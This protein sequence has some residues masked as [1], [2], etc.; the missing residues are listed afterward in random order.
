[1][2]GWFMK[3]TCRSRPLSS[4]TATGDASLVASFPGGTLLAVID[5][6]GHGD[7]AAAAAARAVATL[8]ERPALS[9][10]DHIDRCHTDLRGTRGAAM[11]VLSISFP[12]RRVSW[13]GIGNVEGWLVTAGERTALISRPGVVGYHMAR[14]HERAAALAL[15]DLIVLATDGI[16]P[17]FSADLSRDGDPA[18]LAERIFSVHA[19][20]ED[21][22][23]VL[24]ARCEA[25]P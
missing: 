7:E 2:D 1:M 10:A 24:V 21:D 11:L 18:D 4:E 22:A 12:E 14:P 17:A 5:G 16:A 3:W 19:R 6:L 8:G 23:L 20:E 9:P 13:A 25:P 15:G